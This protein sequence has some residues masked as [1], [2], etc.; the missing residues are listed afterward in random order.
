MTDAGQD[1]DGSGLLT[2]PEVAELLAAAAHHGGGTLVSWQLDHVDASPRRSTT[3]TYTATIDWPFGRREELLGASTRAGGRTTSDEQAVIFAD[4]EREVAV[5]LY[6]RDPDLPGLVRAAFPDQ[7]AALL[8]ERG[9]LGG[10]VEAEQVSLEMI[11]YRPRRR[12]VLKATVAT[13]T[14]PRVF[15][16]K[17]LRPHL[18]APTLMRHRLL[19]DAGVPAPN[20]AAV[21]DDHLLVLDELSGRP[22][23]QAMFEPEEPCSAEALIAVL[24]AMPTEVAA[25]PRRAPWAESVEQYATMVSAAL[26]ALAPRLGW[27]VNQVRAGLDGRA[28]GTDPS[29]GDFHEGQLFVSGGRVSGLLDIDTIGPGRRVDDLA[30]LLAHLSTVQ[31]MNAQ[32]AERVSDLIQTWVPVFD[33]R[34]DPVEL[35][36]SAAA[37]A[38]SLATGPYR[39]QE[40]AWEHET[41]MIV[42]AAERLIRSAG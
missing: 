8:T 33:S 7:M 24:D 14:G 11:G 34:V 22:L 35:R 4:G 30:C 2:S 1:P 10:P 39:G 13:S 21:T 32:Q 40:T 27:I 12:A 41:T 6:P 38:V 19:L 42:D 25:L 9:L 3:A 5:W 37:V 26:P 18:L 16:V 31:R 17:V 28:P 29:H 20:V 15:F 23:A 36:L